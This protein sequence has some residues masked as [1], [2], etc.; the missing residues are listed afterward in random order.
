MEFDY[1]QIAKLNKTPCEYCGKYFLPEKLKVHLQYYCGPNAELTEKQKKTDR[2]NNA[3][4]MMKIGGK[5]TLVNL[6]SLNR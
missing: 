2:K 1:R 5:E 6:T 4:Q 3:V